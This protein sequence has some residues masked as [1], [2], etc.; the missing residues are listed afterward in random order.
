MMETSEV[1][2]NSDTQVEASAG[3]TRMTACG[4]TMRPKTSA[5]RMPSARPAF[6]WPWR[7][8]TMPERNVSELKAEMLQVSPTIAVASCESCM[9]K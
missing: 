5:R 3:S 4:R 7:I 2:L 9:S 8:E 6:H 1:S